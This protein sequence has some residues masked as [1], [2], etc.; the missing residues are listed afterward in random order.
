[1]TGVQTCAL[2]ICKPAF[3]TNCLYDI[4][5]IDHGNKETQTI[6]DTLKQK[7]TDKE[8]KVVQ[9]SNDYLDTFN[10]ILKL[11]TDKKENYIWVCSSICKYDNFDFTYICDPF[12]R[13]QLHVFPSD[14]QKF[15]DTFLV[16]VNKLKE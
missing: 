10:D 13:E 1:M 12:A 16:D 5:V 9:Y 14:E 11:V 3:A 6:V 15:G 7:S 4:Y 8:V 2:P